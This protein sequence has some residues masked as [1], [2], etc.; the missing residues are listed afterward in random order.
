LQ[1]LVDYICPEHFDK[2]SDGACDQSNPFYNRGAL[3][4]EQLE[5]AV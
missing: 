1:F 5:F 3:Q 4:L 2:T